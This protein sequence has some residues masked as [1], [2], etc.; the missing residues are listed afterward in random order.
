VE[1]GCEVDLITSVT[2]CGTCGNICSNGTCISGVCSPPVPGCPDGQISCSSGCIDPSSDPNNCGGCGYN[3]LS[4]PNVSSSL[5]SSGKCIPTC[6][7]G[8]GNC[9]NS[10][11]DGCE[12]NMLVDN[13]YCGNCSTNCNLLPN[14]S[15]TACQWGSCGIV[16]CRNGWADLDG[17]VVNGCE[18]KLDTNPEC[19]SYVYMGSVSGD[20][21][22][23]TLTRTGIGSKWFLVQLTEDDS[24]FLLRYLSATVT[25]ASPSYTDY[26]L[27]VYCYQCGGSLAGSSRNMGGLGQVNVRWDDTP[28]LNSSGY[29]LIEIRFAGGNSASLWTLQVQGNT[30][31]SAVTCLQ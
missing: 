17:D 10:L 15:A 9:N 14:V 22:S 18:Y 19:S 27:Y 28:F 31:V 5:C 20:T 6:K 2:N 29:I 13:T 26:D 30:S 23:S 21:G 4:L 24:G 11:S 12:T 25:L 1:N 16:S 3:C 7:Q 8:Y